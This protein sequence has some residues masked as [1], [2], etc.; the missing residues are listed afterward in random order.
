LSFLGWCAAFG[1][2]RVYDVPT[3]YREVVLTGFAS[4]VTVGR[5][6]YRNAVAS[7]RP[8]AS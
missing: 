8:C 7:G 4:K 5:G 2:Q 6:Q 3:R 1:S